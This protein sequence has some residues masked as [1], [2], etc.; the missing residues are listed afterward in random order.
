M[1]TR[2]Q[3]ILDEAELQEIRAAA[4][5]RRMNVSEWVRLVLR[6][7]RA[8]ERTG[9]T[10]APAVRESVGVYRG[11]ADSPR[12]RVR[13]EIEVKESLLDA[14]QERYRLPTRRAVVEFALRRV[15]VV[16]MSKAEALAMQ[17][18]GWDGDL[19]AIRSGDDPEA[20]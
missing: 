4:E 14:V 6:E 16:P 12:S 11:A 2:L 13:V 9:R 20:L 19:G 5:R 17:G 15:A 7:E 10:S 3:V 1:S 8:R 18:D